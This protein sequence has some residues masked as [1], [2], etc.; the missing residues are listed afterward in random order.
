MTAESLREGVD[1]M[2]AETLKE[3]LVT[4]EMSATLTTNLL[5]RDPMITSLRDNSRERGVESKDSTIGT[6]L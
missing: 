1:P 6:D 4:P 2:M 5:S 3:G